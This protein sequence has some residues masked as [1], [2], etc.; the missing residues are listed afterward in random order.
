MQIRFFQL[1]S[2]PGSIQGANPKVTVNRE[3]DKVTVEP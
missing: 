3:A 1:I 2:T